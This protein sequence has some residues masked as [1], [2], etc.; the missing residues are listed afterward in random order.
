MTAPTMVRNVEW[1]LASVARVVI[2]AA[3]AAGR[4][5]DGERDRLMSAR[6]V[7]GIGNATG[8][9][10]YYGI[11]VYGVWRT[12]DD[13]DDAAPLIE[14]AASAQLSFAQLAL[15]LIHELGHVL[16]GHSAGHGKAWRDACDRLGLRHARAVGGSVW[17]ARAPY[18]IRA[19]IV[20]H[21][22]M[23]TDG[24][25]AFYGTGSAVTVTG[26]G[27][28]RGGQGTRGG[29]SRGT[30]SG[31][32]MV[33]LTCECGKPRVIRGAASTIAL[34]PIVCGVCVKPFTVAS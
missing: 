26:V 10:G 28:C 11:T 32:R 23:V 22:A 14:L 17:L 30:G 15:T 1:F 27:G 6:I 2:M 25:P 34:G 16:A 3:H 8:R 4:I 21:A 24:T 7:Y 33:K 5:D 29:T 13:G 20:A 18:P 31:S 12:G 9:G 19:A